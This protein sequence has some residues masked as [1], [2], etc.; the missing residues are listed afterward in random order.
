M[1]T[2]YQQEKVG[3][4]I[5]TSTGNKFYINQPSALDFSVSDIAHALSNLCRFT[6]HSPRFYS[7]GEHSLHCLDIA[8]HLGASPLKC[9]Y[10]LMHDASEAVM[11]DLARPVKQNVPDYKAL[12]DKISNI[13]WDVCGVP[14]PTKEDYE[15]VKKIDNTMIFLELEQIMGR[16]DLYEYTLLDTFVD[17][18]PSNMIDLKEGFKSGESKG[19]M[20][21]EYMRLI[22]L[23]YL[24]ENTRKILNNIKEMS[25]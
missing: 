11:N 21:E 6:G 22:E 13:M 23:Y 18:I 7:V 25:V 14:A 2:T 24:E 9:I 19:A 17:D 3:D 5:T 20:I 1:T 4:Y 16:K 8:I 12:E 15:F 10:A